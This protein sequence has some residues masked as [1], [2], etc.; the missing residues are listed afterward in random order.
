VTWTIVV[1]VKGGPLAK[2]R[3]GSPLKL[4]EAVALDTIAAAAA[5][6]AHIVVVSS[7]P[8]SFG[9]AEVIA[10]PGTGLMDAVRAGIRGRSGPVAVLL[11]DHPGLE[12]AELVGAFA[13]AQ[14]HPLA[15]VADADGTGSALATA[16]DGREHRLAFGPGSAAAHVA[17]GYV[18]LD[19][20]WPGLRRDVDLL[21]HFDDLPNLGP[22]TTAFLNR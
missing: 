7:A 6:G 1:P 16:L 18:P 15:F 5:T 17:A 3:L 12:P 19:G 21:E 10:D 14:T 4:A 9:G 22:R 11:G 13:Q 8:W 20:D 2:S